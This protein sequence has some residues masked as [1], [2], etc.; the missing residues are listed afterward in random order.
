MSVAGC[1]RIMAFVRVV[2]PIGSDAAEV[3]FRRDLVEQVGQHWSI[4]DAAARDL[5]CLYL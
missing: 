3:L 2:S 4:A 1:Y 5:N